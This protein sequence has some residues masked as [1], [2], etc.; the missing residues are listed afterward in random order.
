MLIK[1]HPFQRKWINYTHYESHSPSLHS[2]SSV[3]SMDLYAKCYGK[4]EGRHVQAKHELPLTKT[5]QA[6]ALA[7]YLTYKQQISKLSHQYDTI[8]QEEEP[9]ISSQADY[10]EFLQSRT[11]QQFVFTVIDMYSGHAFTC[12]AHNASVISHH[13]LWTNRMAYAPSW[14]ATQLFASDQEITSKKKKCHNG[15]LPMK[16]TGLTVVSFKRSW[17]DQKTK[18]NALLKT[19]FNY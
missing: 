9:A 2:H 13:C 12:S 10:T 6:T 1:R 14:F 16:M 11:K 5:N 17:P 15:L 4:R 19:H 7:D 8:F 3:C 18:C